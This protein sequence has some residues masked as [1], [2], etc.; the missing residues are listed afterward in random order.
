MMQQTTPTTK[1]SEVK[2]ESEEITF[3]THS[4]NHKPKQA[5]N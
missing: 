5:L 1:S 2:N 4:E 3:D